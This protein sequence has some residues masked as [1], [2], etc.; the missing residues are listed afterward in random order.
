MESDQKFM[1]WIRDSSIAC[2]IYFSSNNKG[3]IT[4]HKCKY[5][6]YTRLFDV[7]IFLWLSFILLCFFIYITVVL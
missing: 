7:N 2:N 4:V 1:A 3:A 5:P 6:F